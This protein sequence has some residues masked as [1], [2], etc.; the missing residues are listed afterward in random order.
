LQHNLEDDPHVEALQADSPSPACG[1]GGTGAGFHAQASSD[2]FDRQLDIAHIDKYNAPN[3]A[4]QII[5]SHNYKR[6]G[7]NSDAG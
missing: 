2:S 5:A 3:A 6:S 4:C 7:I 1:A